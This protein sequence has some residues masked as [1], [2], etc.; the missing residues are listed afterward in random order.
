[1]TSSILRENQLLLEG[2]PDSVG[3]FSVAVTTD[4]RL[5]CAYDLACP[6]DNEG[7]YPR[8]LNLGRTQVLAGW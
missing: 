2:I 5:L 7:A 1:M 4:D 8:G 3:T 6:V